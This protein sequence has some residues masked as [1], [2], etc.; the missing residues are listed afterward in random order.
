MASHLSRRLFRG[1]L[2]LGGAVATTAGLDTVVRGARSL[3]SQ[4]LANAG[5]ESDLRFYAAFYLAYGLTILRV[6]SRSEPEPAHVRAVAGALFLAGLA[7]ATAWRE[8]GPPHRLQQALLVLELALP[9][10]LVGWQE[11]L[12]RAN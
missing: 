7:R 1:A 4:D 2:F 11:R 5:L 8:V 10:T 9:P 3:P 12:T 6:G